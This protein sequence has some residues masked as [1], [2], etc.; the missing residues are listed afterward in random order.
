M[1]VTS[2]TSEEMQRNKEEFIS[3]ITSLK[4]I[5]DDEWV[6]TSRIDLLVD[7]LVK[8]DFFYAPAS[9]K[10]HGAY[11]GGL[12]EH[13]LQVYHTLKELVEL[14]C[15][16]IGEDSIIICGLLHDF[17]KVNTYIKTS[18]NK[19]VYHN[20]GSKHDELGTFDWVAEL[21]YKIDH[22]HKFVYGNHE[23]TCEYLIRCFIPLKTE[24]SIAI[25]HHHGGMGFDSTKLNIT[26][27]YNNCPLACL[28]HSADLLCTYI[29]QGDCYAQPNDCITTE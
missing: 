21:G 7:Y 2:V 26:D 11:E 1:S 28:L 14:K 27:I 15:L 12:C 8:S 29:D 19:K 24:E 16:P 22:D 3:L 13:C 17:A 25:L 6:N 23:E 4:D 10:Y 18:V 9:S 20:N 5:R